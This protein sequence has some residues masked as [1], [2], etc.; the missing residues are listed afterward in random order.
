MLFALFGL[1]PTILS[2]LAAVCSVRL[3][4]CAL[5][6]QLL[7]FLTLLG[8]SVLPLSKASLWLVPLAALLLYFCGFMAAVFMLR[9]DFSR[10]EEGRTGVLGC[11]LLVGLNLAL[12]VFLMHHVLDLMR[13]RLDNLVS[14]DGLRLLLWEI[15]MG[16]IV[17][18]LWMI[19]FGILGFR[20]LA[21]SAFYAGPG[22]FFSA[23]LLLANLAG[24]GPLHMPASLA[25]LLSLNEQPTYLI[26]PPGALLSGAACL[27]PLPAALLCGFLGSLLLERGQGRRGKAQVRE[28]A[29]PPVRAGSGQILK[30][31]HDLR[32]SDGFKA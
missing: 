2:V 32:R 4:L 8:Y 22:L 6:G 7:Y 9:R 17:L 12:L 11:A 26:L 28:R 15:R 27:L 20:R 1:T 5:H 18:P 25:A 24:A 10:L 14:F 19:V 3:G 16:A 31:A 30:P 21:L 29:S 13:L 23:Y